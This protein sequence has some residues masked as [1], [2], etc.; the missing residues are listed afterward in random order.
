LARLVLALRISHP[1]SHLVVAGNIIGDYPNISSL[2]GAD[3]VI[4]DI[5]TA[6][7]KLRMVVDQPVG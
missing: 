3:A 2:V 6:V 4:K 7:A 5:E 1:L